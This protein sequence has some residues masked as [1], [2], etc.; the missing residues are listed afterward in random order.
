V[1]CETCGETIPAEEIASDSLHR[2]EGASD[3]DDMAVVVAFT[4]P[5]CGTRDALVLTYGSEASG[6]DADVLAA[7]PEHHAGE[8]G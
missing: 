4:C 7:L 5:R 6:A 3:P 1:R 2:V 8:S